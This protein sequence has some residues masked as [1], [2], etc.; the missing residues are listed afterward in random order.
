MTEI[1][2]AHDDYEITLINDKLYTSGSADNK[3][4]YSKEYKNQ[5]VFHFV[6]KLG[7]VVTKLSKEYQ[8]AIILGSG[9]ASGL[10]ETSFILNSNSL[11]MC[12]DH[13]IVCLNLPFLDLEWRKQIDDATCFE[14][15]KFMNDFIIHGE[16]SISRI[17]INGNI[18]WTFYGPDI[19]T[20]EMRIEGN[21]VIAVDFNNNVFKIDI[22]N[23]K[24]TQ[25]G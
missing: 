22:E 9:G 20:E 2:V 23:G 3:R 13:D 4:K 17:D 12:V 1:I 15:L 8:S 21:F 5:D 11:L 18:M 14:I 24:G 7:I 19:F 25:V 6:T 16:L 10:H